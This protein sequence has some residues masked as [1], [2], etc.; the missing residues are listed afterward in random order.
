M[1][2]KMEK[3]EN[4]NYAIEIGK[5]L[6]FSLIGIDGSDIYNGS[7]TLTLGSFSSLSSSFSL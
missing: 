5:A 3:L 1:K 4:C 2:M 7:T 6:K